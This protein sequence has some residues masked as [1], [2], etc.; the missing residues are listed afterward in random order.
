VGALVLVLAGVVRLVRA[1]WL[2]RP[3]KPS[4]PSLPR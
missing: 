4:R 2:R 3:T 1:F